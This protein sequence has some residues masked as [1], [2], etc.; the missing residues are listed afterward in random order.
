MPPPRA[1]LDRDKQRHIHD[2]DRGFCTVE[3]K[4][5]DPY[6]AMMLARSHAIDNYAMVEQML[7]RLFERLSGTEP[8]VAAEIFFK[9]SNARVRLD[10]MH[11]L[12]KRKKPAEFRLFWNS[13]K[14]FAIKLSNERNQIVHWVQNADWGIILS[15]EEKD[16]PD[17]SRLSGANIY[18][19]NKN[20]PTKSVEDVLDF[21]DRCRYASTRI[22]MFVSVMDGD[23]NHEPKALLES[24]LA[25]L[26]YP[27]IDSE[28][29]VTPSKWI[30]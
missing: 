25:P 7:C 28:F 24:F 18:W 10:I 22:G 14:K 29:A 12:I 20:S 8:G 27:P 3:I 5:K 19:Q 21:A 30:R 13:L 1:Y 6:E 15:K 9:I 11:N 23:L 2:A 16:F 4:T 26:E 17:D